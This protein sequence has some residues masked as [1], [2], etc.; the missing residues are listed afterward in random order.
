MSIGAAGG[1]QPPGKS[2]HPLGGGGACPVMVDILIRAI[3]NVSFVFLF[4]FSFLHFQEMKK[5]SLYMK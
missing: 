1:P 2:S 4:I 5:N 3:S